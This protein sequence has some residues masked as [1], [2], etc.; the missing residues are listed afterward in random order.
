MNDTIKIGE[1]MPE[2]EV[3]D[4]GVKTESLSH[5]A[6]VERKND[7]AQDKPQV[8]E[9]QESDEKKDDDTASKSTSED[10]LKGTALL[11]SLLSTSTASLVPVVEKMITTTEV[12]DETLKL[13]KILY[14]PDK[15]KDEVKESETSAQ[16]GQQTNTNDAPADEDDRRLVIDI[17]DEENDRKNNDKS[18]LLQ[19]LSKEDENKV[20]RR[21]RPTH[22]ETGPP[23]MRPI[24]HQ[25]RLQ[26]E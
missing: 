12:T 6:P 7:E 13:K 4:D 15:E 3:N 26:S 23:P 17:S 9:K 10:G 2:Q 21:L 25:V 11:K 19:N 8:D 18:I 14:Q 5:L 24:R 22:L 20:Q 16:N 1:D